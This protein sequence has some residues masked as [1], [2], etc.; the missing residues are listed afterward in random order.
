MIIDNAF[1]KLKGDEFIL[2]ERYIYAVEYPL[3]DAIVGEGSMW[4]L[5]IQMAG[6]FESVPW[7]KTKEDAVE[8]YELIASRIEELA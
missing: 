7:F 2:N 4:S 1:N 6:G 8:T 5:H 3:R